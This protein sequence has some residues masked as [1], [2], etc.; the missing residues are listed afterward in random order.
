M[1]GKHSKKKKSIPDPEPIPRSVSV[2]VIHQKQPITEPALSS[3]GPE[4]PTHGKNNIKVPH[5]LSAP[6]APNRPTQPPPVSPNKPISE[7]PKPPL[8]PPD[9]NYDNMPLSNTPIS[10]TAPSVSS[11]PADTYEK[12]PHSISKTSINEQFMSYQQNSETTSKT[13]EEMPSVGRKATFTPERPTPPVKPSGQAISLGSLQ[14]QLSKKKIVDSHEVIPNES[15]KGEDISYGSLPNPNPQ[16]VPVAAPEHHYSNA[17]PDNAN[18]LDMPSFKP[19]SGVNYDDINSGA[20]TRTKVQA[21]PSLKKEVLL[22]DKSGASFWSFF[23]LAQQVEV[24]HLF[25]SFK[26]IGLTVPSDLH[27][28]LDA[29]LRGF[30]NYC[31]QPKLN[32]FVS[33]FGPLLPDYA[34]FQLF[35]S[36]VKFPAFVGYKTRSEAEYLLGS[37]L[38]GTYMVRI[39]QS[40]IG[41]FTISFNRN[42]RVLHATLR[43]NWPVGFNLEIDDKTITLKTFNEAFTNFP[44][45]F[46]TSFTSDFLWE[47]WY[48]GDISS[49][50]AIQQLNKLPP[51]SFLIRASQSSPG[52]FAVTLKTITGEIDHSLIQRTAD[53]SFTV[54]INNQNLKFSSLSELVNG[55][56]FLAKLN[57]EYKSQLYRL[58]N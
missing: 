12:M 50:D 8:S 30:D 53:K 47:P 31:T 45:H 1:G 28:P 3:S 7:P 55:V 22:L 27:G 13:Y 20:L 56:K 38:H 51:S 39:S 36:V 15:L 33:L 19:S 46:G 58:K 41:C 17:V 29:M 44:E 16:H 26:S 35:R 14:S 54:C 21:Q 5:K 49:T 52:A 6:P 4:L 11:A 40:E 48:A 32:S 2:E 9:E 24:H 25:N 57:G 42:G 34:P 10:P 43:K 23:F 37:Q 18:Y